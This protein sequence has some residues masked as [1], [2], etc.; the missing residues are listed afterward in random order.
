MEIMTTDDAIIFDRDDDL[1]TALGN[2]SVGDELIINDR[3]I[4]LEVFDKDTEIIGADA[5]PTATIYLEGRGGRVYRIRYQ[6]AP[7]EPEIGMS[8]TPQL[9]LRK[10]CGWSILKCISRLELKE[11]QQIMCDTRAGEWLQEAGIDV[12]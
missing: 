8:Y 12:R 7:D 3:T 6:Y 9:E 10:E 11:G 1:Q 2:V 4:A 5:Y